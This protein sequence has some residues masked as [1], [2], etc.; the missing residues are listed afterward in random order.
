M[1]HIVHCKPIFSKFMKK[2]M[3]RIEKNIEIELTA[4]V[5]IFAINI[6]YATKYSLLLLPVNRKI[7]IGAIINPTKEL[8]KYLESIK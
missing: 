4:R 5:R 2:P 3:Y 8:K 6:N 7:P 1:T